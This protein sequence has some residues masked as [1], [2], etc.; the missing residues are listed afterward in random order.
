MSRRLLQA[1]LV[2]VLCAACQSQGSAQP[3]AKST[4]RP[5][6]VTEIAKFNTPWA[7]AFL[8]GSGRPLLDAAL[9]TEKEGRLWLID[10]KDGRRWPVTGVPAVKVAGQGGLGDVAVHPEFVVNHRVYLSF[11]EAGPSGTSG[12]ALGYGT[13]DLANRERPAL[14]D[15]KVIWRQQPK[16]TGDGHFS[17]R[18]AFGPDGLI[19]LSSG[20]R[21]KMAPAQ[22]LSGNLGKV[23]RLTPEGGPALGNP[24]DRHGGIAA[25]FWSI[26]H[27]NVLGLQFAPDGRLWA[28][29]MGPQ[30]GDEVNLVLPG[31]NYGWPRASNGSHYGGG[32]IPD[33][34][35]GDG[36]EA[37][38]IWWTPSISPGALLI[39]SGGKFPKWKGDALVGALSGK[40]LIR[41]DIDG[42]KAVKAD[43]WDMG[44]RIRA[45]DQGPDGSIYLLEDGG[46][47]LRLDPAAAP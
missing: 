2:A 44:E 30:G 3:D 21:Q 25:Q 26:G 17:H 28:S 31:R 43:H 22:D 23:L 46:R 8:T 47:L 15:F 39:Y 7:M 36:F 24:W 42:D 41:I 11:V 18:I 33:H 10:S 45:V 19:Y 37:P 32:D 5:F 38:R 14:R 29:E 9:V 34:R 1:A 40:A 13:L 12:A 4:D 20:D 6:T 16:V 27:R 35:S